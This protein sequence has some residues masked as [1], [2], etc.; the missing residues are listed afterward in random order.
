MS[1]PSDPQTPAEW[2]QYSQ[3]EI[4]SSIPLR[5]EHRTEQKTNIERAVYLDESKIESPADQLLYLYT[6]VFAFTKS[7]VTIAPQAY[8]EIQLIARVLTADTP[9]NL[10]FIPDT[11]YHTYIY[12]SVIDQPISVSLGNDSSEPLLLKLGSATGIVGVKLTVFPDHIVPTYQTAYVRVVDVDLQASLDT[13]L[14]VALAL[15][16]RNTS[17]AISICSYVASLTS[18]PALSAYSRIN[19]QAGALGQQLAAQAMTGPDMGYAP[20]LQ[21]DQYMSTVHDALDAVSAF[22]DQY[23]RFQDN[24]QN[25]ENLKLAWSSLL[26]HAQS[27]LTQDTIL[28]TAAWTKYQDACTV[29]ARSQEQMNADN[30]EVDNAKSAFLEGLEA[31]IARTILFAAYETLSAIVKFTNAIGVLSLGF[32]SSLGDAAKD[33]KDAINDVRKAEKGLDQTGKTISSATLEN[34]GECM[35]ALESLYPSTADLVA[36]IKKLE[37]DPHADI[38]SSATVTGSSDGDADARTIITLA[39]WDKWGLEADKQLAYAV[40]QSI[41]GASAYQL[42]LRKQAV[43]G[44]ALAQAQAEAVKAGHEYTQA[45]IEVIACNQDIDTLKNLLDTYTEEKEQYAQAKAKFFDRFLQ[46][47]TSLILQMQKLVWAYKYRALADSSVTLDSQE[48]T[49]EFENYLLTLD[50]EIQAADER[51]AT[52]F[53]P[54]E[55][56][57]PC[58]KLPANYGD[59]MIQGLQG[60]S[61]SAS[62]TLAPT[63]DSSDNN[64]F[65]SLFNDGSHFRLEGLETFLQGVVPRAEAIS[66]GVAHVNIDIL[67]SGVYADIQDGKIFHFTSLPRQVR[68]TYE[69]DELGAIGDTLVHATYPTK[70]H[71]EPTPFTQW[72]IRLL[73]P[74]DLDLTKLTGVQ[75]HWKGSVRFVGNLS[76]PST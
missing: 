6:D 73:N 31:W 16:W 48:P 35:Q 59:L 38:P 70:E 21:V 8:A 3:S 15:F 28:R 45:A 54:F 7:E 64:S 68:L 10:K 52:D 17:L 34:L 43:D 37:S 63:T 36:A 22:E 62:F 67:T 26:D 4:V 19:A 39:A 75:L 27:Q 55:Y 71:A 47:R 18:N 76:A 12:A 11:G 20:V 1:I 56:K 32:K 5:E 69:I 46:I 51:Y 29:V 58:S 41:T 14:R 2:L 25:V 57:Q 42:A 13:Q 44:K 53:Q 72:T 60:E 74:D 49:G 24:E 61:H 66:D 9:V 40:G 65:A 30:K 50:S 23:Q 33:I